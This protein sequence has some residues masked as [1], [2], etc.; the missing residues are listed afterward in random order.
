MP[1]KIVPRATLGTLAVGCRRLVWAY[2]VSP[3]SNTS[4]PVHCLSCSLQ[5]LHN[6]LACL[7]HP[8]YHS[9]G[10]LFAVLQCCFFLSCASLFSMNVCLKGMF[11]SRV[12]RLCTLL[13]YLAYIY[14]VCEQNFRDEILVQ[15]SPISK[16]NSPETY[17]ERAS[18]LW[19]PA[20]KHLILSF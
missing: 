20:E 9:Q 18:K 2:R 16:H 15:N 13:L 19:T 8:S 12:T 10:K 1:L 4:K 3:A 11:C 6:H 17:G 7:F 5:L 14:T